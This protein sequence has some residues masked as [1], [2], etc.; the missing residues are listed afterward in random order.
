MLLNNLWVTVNTYS[1]HLHTKTIIIL[2]NIM[3]VKPSVSVK[4]EGWTDSGTEI[5]DAVICRDEPSSPSSTTPSPGRKNKEV[6]K[7][8]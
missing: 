6:N 2:I 8:D 7:C 5:W 4:H 1:P 3:R